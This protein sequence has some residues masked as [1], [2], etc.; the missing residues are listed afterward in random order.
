MIFD[1]LHDS[2]TEYDYSVTRFT[3]EAS[4][5]L[6]DTFISAEDIIQAHSTAM[7]MYLD[8]FDTIFC[9]D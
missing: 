5:L 4:D 7:K 9:Q 6:V 2:S 1:Q 8:D 3:T